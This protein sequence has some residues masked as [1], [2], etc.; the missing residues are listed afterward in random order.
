MMNNI[1]LTAEQIKDAVAAALG[2]AVR[3]LTVDLGK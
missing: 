1:S 3:R 2:K